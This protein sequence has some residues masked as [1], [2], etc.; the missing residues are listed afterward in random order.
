VLCG[1]VGALERRD[2]AGVGTDV[3]MAARLMGK[4][5]SRILIDVNTHKILNQDAQKLLIPAE[6][7]V[8]KGM[9]GPCIPY[10]Y[11][12]TTLPSIADID[13]ESAQNSVLRPAMQAALIRLLDTFMNVGTA[14]TNQILDKKLRVCFAFLFGMPGTGKNLA[15]QYYRS[16]ARLRGVNCIHLI[17]RSDSQGIPYGLLRELFLELVGKSNFITQHQQYSKMCSLIEEICDDTDSEEDRTNALLSLQLVL[18]VD[19]DMQH[20]YD[21]E[22]TDLFDNDTSDPTTYIRMETKHSMSRINST[23]SRKHD[24]YTFY[25]VVAYLLRNTPTVVIIEN[26][27]YVDELS[28]KELYLM[29][30]GDQLDMHILLTMEV[31]RIPEGAY[32]S[33]LIGEYCIFVF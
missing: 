2:Y 30:A 23:S 24:D 22:H 33:E 6:E 11:N 7:M 15:V 27:H 5:K 17:A 32:K 20:I 31:S 8:L 18:G 9:G 16:T 19:I 14:D 3:N 26:A 28:W 25:N 10:Q 1:G 4:A 21:V 29:Q 13:V 12:A